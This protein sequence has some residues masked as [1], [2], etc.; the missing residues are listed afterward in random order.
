MDNVLGGTV[1]IMSGYYYETVPI[2]A[3][4]IRVYGTNVISEPGVAIDLDLA[5]N[6]W[7]RD[8]YNPISGDVYP[9]RINWEGGFAYTG[10]S[11]GTS[12]PYTIKV[13]GGDDHLYSSR[14][15]SYLRFKNVCIV[16]ESAAAPGSG[17]NLFQLR[18]NI[19][20][21]S[22]TTLYL[23]GCRIYTAGQFEPI[24]SAQNVGLGGFRYRIDIKSS[25]LIWSGEYELST[26]NSYNCIW[27]D[28]DGSQL[29]MRNSLI[30]GINSSANG[31]ESPIYTD[32]NRNLISIDDI[33]FHSLIGS[34][35]AA[36]LLPT[37]Y[38]N[39]AP[40]LPP[41]PIY[42]GARCISEYDVN[43]QCSNP[44]LGDLSTGLFFPTPLL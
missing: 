37:I 28:N 34:G 30:W 38:S 15:D 7:I 9:I 27:L 1:H 18:G 31:N 36:G 4:Q 41:S 40:P 22:A 25:E 6:Y 33:Q 29:N 24:I 2:I 20:G 14:V 35:G 17:N 44:L 32:S 12:L 13:L 19:N 42:I 23:D 11:P 39:S 16:K 5:N 8:I 21:G 26:A 3:T 10:D 43:F